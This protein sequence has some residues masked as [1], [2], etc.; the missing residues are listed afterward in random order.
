MKLITFLD[1][2]LRVK[3]ESDYLHRIISKPEAYNSDKYYEKLTG[4]GTL[5]H[6][7]SISENLNA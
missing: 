5:T 6:T 7:Y 2:K 4:F 1:E 3:E